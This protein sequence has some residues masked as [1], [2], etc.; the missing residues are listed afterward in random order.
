MASQPNRSVGARPSRT[1]GVV[2]PLVGGFYFGGVIAGV[3]RAAARA[4]MRVV[5]VQT[6]PTRLAREQHP[7]AALPGSPAALDVMDGIVVVTEALSPGMLQRLV[8][9]GRPVVLVGA[10]A[11]TDDT[12]SVRPDNTG[13]A[14][15]AVE[16]LVQHG[17]TRIGFVGD[18]T[19]SD[20]RE[21]YQGYL[22]ALAARGIRPTDEWFALA[23]DNTVQGGIDAA[24]ALIARNMPTTATLAATDLAAIGLTRGLQ[25]G[26]I[27]LPTDHAIIGFDH[28]EGGARQAPRL[29]TVDPHHDLVGEQA[30]AQL[31]AGLRGTEAGPPHVA[32]TLVARESCGCRR[33]TTPTP[34]APDPGPVSAGRAA[35]HRIITTAFDG[36]VRGRAA[37]RGGDGARATWV[38]TILDVLDTAAARG[39]RPSDAAL[40]RLHDLTAALGP[41]PE[42]LE[43]CIAAVRQLERE[44]VEAAPDDGR[45]DAVQRAVTEVLLVLTRGCLRPFL[46]RE[47]ALERTISDQYEVDMDLVSARSGSPR[48]LTWLPA[49]GRISA[50]LGLWT[51]TR[52]SSG[53][54]ELEI[55]G[56]QA[57]SGTLAR[58][59]GRRVASAQFPPAAL[60]RAEPLD[61]ATLVFVVPVTSTRA[62]WGLLAVSGRLDPRMTYPRER[63]QHWGAMLAVALD[64]E[65]QMTSLR[66]AAQTH[67]AEAASGRATI[68]ALRVQDERTSLWL[69]ALEHGLWDWDVATGS[70]FWSP[71]WANLLGLRAEDLGADPEEWLD[72]VHPDDRVVVSALVAAQLGG[73]TEPMRVEHRVKHASGKYRWM[74]CV[75]FAVTNDAGVPARI[76]GAMLDVTDRRIREA[77]LSR[78][79][80]R[81]P[82]TGWATPAAFVDR[83]EDARDRARA[84]GGDA[85]LAVLRHV[86]PAPGTCEP[87]EALATVGA[88]LSDALGHGDAIGRLTADSLGCVLVDRPDGQTGAARL[89]A[90]LEHLPAEHRRRLAAGLVESVRSF[91][92]VGD[93]LRAAE[94]AALRDAPDGVRR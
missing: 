71:Q 16:H 29:T 72:R 53:D 36:P 21:R 74:L 12:P 58:S 77:A 20:I 4:G 84:A 40:R 86:S 27:S 17:H 31:L 57:R 44:L 68:D 64:Q 94:V 15:A 35:L 34:S 37:V 19:Q 75:A 46:I 39:T 67:E 47:S 23:P 85:A 32:A 42:T 10:D 52:S 90:V 63:H 8:D 1:I 48:S 9:D 83:L 81:D 65:Q 79:T 92:D 73:A 88:A 26:G 38:S 7:N 54:R 62:D 28:T 66:E 6:F 89:A 18:L 55:A 3:T 5:A 45:R 70:V 14:R 22:D 25:A 43:Q 82:A 91:D 87:P 13:G 50:C 93:L 61:G 80:L 60:L 41:Y 24:H 56:A 69:R 78:G 49:G 11:P 59:V 33:V 51:G 30:V 76:V 2:S